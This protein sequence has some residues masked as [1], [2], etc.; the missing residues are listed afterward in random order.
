MP[1]L[2]QEAALWIA[3]PVPGTSFHLQCYPNATIDRLFEQA[4]T[5]VFQGKGYRLKGRITT[6][7]VDSTLRNS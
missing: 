1:E 2:P 3:I 7:D 4:H 6:R 5:V